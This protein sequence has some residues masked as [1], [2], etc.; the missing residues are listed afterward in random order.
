MKV[1]VYDEAAN[2]TPKQWKEL[3]KI[4]Q[5]W[6]KLELMTK[7]IPDNVWK[8]IDKIEEVQRK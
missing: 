3:D 1:K 6:E 4:L 5:H 8:G 2:I 7:S